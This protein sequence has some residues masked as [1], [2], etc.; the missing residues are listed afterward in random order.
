MC[1]NDEY[2]YKH[3]SF[4]RLV[5]YISLKLLPEYW[6]TSISNLWMH[7]SSNTLSFLSQPKE[8]VEN[9]DRK[10]LDQNGNLF[11]GA[12]LWMILLKL[13]KGYTYLSGWGGLYNRDF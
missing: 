13:L 3:P 7:A 1:V 9:G 6:E 10:T 2:E 4:F 11:Y 8:W 5:N 12:F